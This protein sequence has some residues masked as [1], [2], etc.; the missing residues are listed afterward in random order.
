MHECAIAG[1]AQWSLVLTCCGMSSTCTARYTS[2]ARTIGTPLPAAAAPAVGPRAL[3]RRLRC[4]LPAAS[5]SCGGLNKSRPVLL[6]AAEPSTLRFWRLMPSGHGSW[7][8]KR[9][10]PKQGWA[11]SYGAAALCAQPSQKTRPEL[12]PHIAASV[13]AA[14]TYYECTITAHYIA[15]GVDC[16]ISAECGA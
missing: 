5:G 1:V 15:D 6:E 12:K 11:T 10:M 16:G 14:T 2:T 7:L 3:P 4:A 9:E 13:T 8:A